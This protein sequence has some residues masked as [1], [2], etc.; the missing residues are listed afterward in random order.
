MR[1]LFVSMLGVGVAVVI[2]GCASVPPPTD[3]LAK[4]EGSIRGAAEVGAQSIPAASLYL[5]LAQ[6]EFQT[7][8]ALMANGD[9][10]RA[11][12]VFLRANADAELAL[13]IARENQAKTGANHAA[14]KMQKFQET[15]TP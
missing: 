13:N 14:E 11:G 10:E 1:P 4:S 3:R 2:A 6:E 12:Y 5:K 7:A 15:G 8:K 9:N